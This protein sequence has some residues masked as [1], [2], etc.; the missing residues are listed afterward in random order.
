MRSGFYVLSRTCFRSS[1]SSGAFC[2]III[3]ETVVLQ[4]TNCGHP[5]FAAQTLADPHKSNSAPNGL[6]APMVLVGKGAEHYC[7]AL[8][9]GIVENNHL[10]RTE[11]ALRNHTL[12]MKLHAR[13]AQQG[14]GRLDTVGGVSIN[15]SEILSI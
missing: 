12:A 9:I 10:L 13:D 3:Y 7:E 1:G 15:V 5:S 4:V 14:N 8:S 11:D 2:P 6:I